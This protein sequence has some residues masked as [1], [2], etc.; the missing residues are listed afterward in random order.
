VDILNKQMKS[1]NLEQKHQK[2]TTR[3]RA[4]VS[5]KNK[6]IT[7][8]PTMEKVSPAPVVDQLVADAKNSLDDFGHLMFYEWYRRTNTFLALNTKSALNFVESFAISARHY[9]QLLQY[10]IKRSE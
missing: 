4:P 7:D 10:K 5:Q 8:K 3:R 9:Q 6:N 1:L 2:V